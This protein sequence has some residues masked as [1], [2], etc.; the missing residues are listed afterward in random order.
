MGRFHVKT[1][2]LSKLAQE[3]SEKSGTSRKKRD[4]WHVWE[5]YFQIE[6]E[7]KVV[8]IE[9]AVKSNQ[10]GS[11]AYKR[12]VSPIIFYSGICLLETRVLLTK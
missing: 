12:I 6:I 9:S 11:V 5:L 2:H 7:Y 1:G 3:K 8:I 4:G 10:S